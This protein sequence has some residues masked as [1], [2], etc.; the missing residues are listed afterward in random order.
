MVSQQSGELAGELMLQD[1]AYIRQ[2]RDLIL[3]ERTR[4]LK[5]LENI[6]TYKTYP[7]YATFSS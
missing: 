5:A 3:S 1:E 2:T 4:L 6:P 7:A